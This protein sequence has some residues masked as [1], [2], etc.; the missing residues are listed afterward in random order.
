MKKKKNFLIWCGNAGLGKTHL[1]AALVEW[2]LKNFSSYRK[3]KESD[4]QKK[5][6][7]SM[8]EAKGDYLDYLKF[9]IDDELLM[10]DDI[11][12]DGHSDW[13]EEILIETV[14]QRYNSLLPT[15]FTSNLSSKEIIEKYH[16]RISGRLFAKENCIIEIMDGKDHRQ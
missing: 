12:R 3:Y 9:F 13:R 14:D 5:V 2:A 10:I 11:G 16:E 8:N 15:I 4:L 7:G 6:R 1:G